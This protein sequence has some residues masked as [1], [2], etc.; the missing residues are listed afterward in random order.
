MDLIEKLDQLEA[1]NKQLLIMNTDLESEVECLER[2]LN[3]VESEYLDTSRELEEA[4][5]TIDDL[6][7]ELDELS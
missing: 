2:E 6:E 3:Y 1:D 4:L 5:D 7:N